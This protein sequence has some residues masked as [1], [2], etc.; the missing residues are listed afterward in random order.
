M[1]DILTSRDARE[2]G[3]YNVEEILRD[4]ERHRKGQIMA[5]P[6]LFNIAQF[7][8][9]TEMVKDGGVPDM[10]WKGMD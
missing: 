9:L 4:L 2:S 5:S 10:I 1:M 7:Q 3:I 8:I 6:R